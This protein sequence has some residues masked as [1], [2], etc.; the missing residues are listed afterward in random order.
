M[1]KKIISLILIAILIL[2]PTGCSKPK[3]CI[4]SHIERKLIPTTII[5]NG[6]HVFMMRTQIIRVCDEYEELGE[7]EK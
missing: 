2:M 4:K 7:L 5:I 3:K 6:R 1:N